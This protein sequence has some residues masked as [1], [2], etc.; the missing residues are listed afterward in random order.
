MRLRQELSL[1]DILPFG[2]HKGLT[3]EEII[4]EYPDYMEWLTDEAGVELDEVASNVLE[5]TLDAIALG[6]RSGDK[7]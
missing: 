6:L 7:K 1:D 4:K 5:E 3:V 2:K